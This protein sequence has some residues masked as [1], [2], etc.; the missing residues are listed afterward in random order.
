M[1]ISSVTSFTLYR[2]RV[3]L[4][5]SVVFGVWG[6]GCTKLASPQLDED[7]KASW[8][9]ANATTDKSDSGD[10]GN[11]G[12]ADAADAVGQASIDSL[13]PGADSQSKT[14][15]LR[16]AS[17]GATETDIGEADPLVKQLTSLK[18][19]DRKEVEL[20]EMYR[21]NL[22]ELCE[23]LYQLRVRCPLLTHIT[24]R[25]APLVRC[26]KD[27]H[28]ERGYISIQFHLQGVSG[29]DHKTSLVFQTS[30]GEKLSAE[31]PAGVGLVDQADFRDVTDFT[32][33]STKK[34][35]D[36]VQISLVSEVPFSH[37]GVTCLSI[38]VNGTPILHPPE[39]VCV[40]MT[41]TTETKYELK[42]AGLKSLIKMRQQP[43]CQPNLK[44]IVE[45]AS[46]A[47]SGEGP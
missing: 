36:V 8:L 5:T 41:R 17:R 34:I 23:E 10:G 30:D 38:E 46:P 16:E 24:T 7:A 47:K 28:Q 43:E 19:N 20:I 35:K 14:Y 1:L 21:K 2:F 13:V 39:E 32:R 22:G 45:S 26:K 27:I 44:D 9:S 29:F 6:V 31:I 4:T 33:N 42:G 40:T 25:I 37:A 15:E 18:E 11:G 12:E 3:L